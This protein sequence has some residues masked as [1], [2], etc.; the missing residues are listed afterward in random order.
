MNPQL[1][2]S[3]SYET[4]D[5]DSVHE[6]SIYYPF[7]NISNI[8]LVLE[9]QR[10]ERTKGISTKMLQNTPNKITLEEKNISLF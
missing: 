4:I 2:H 8:I 7:Y 6:Y 1:D 10:E 5:V 3:F 9:N